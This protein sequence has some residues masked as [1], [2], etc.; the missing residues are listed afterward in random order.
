[1]EDFIENMS[2]FFS[3]TIGSKE[4][5]FSGKPKSYWV[6]FY[7]NVKDVFIC[8]NICDTVNLGLL[9]TF[10]LASEALSQVTKMLAS[11]RDFYCATKVTIEIHFLNDVWVMTHQIYIFM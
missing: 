3:F 5:V 8:K 10:T 2:Y 4:T 11:R 7:T 1:M 6:G 9:G